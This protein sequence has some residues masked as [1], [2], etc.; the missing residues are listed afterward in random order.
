MASPRLLY[1]N[2]PFAANFVGPCLPGPAT[3]TE[4]FA[5]GAR[6]CCPQQDLSNSNATSPVDLEHDAGQERR[7]VAGEKEGGGPDVLRHRK[8][9]ERHGGAERGALSGVSSPRNIANSGVSPATGASAQTRILSGASS[10]A[11]DFVITCTAP[12]EAL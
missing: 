8:A 11:I 3:F 9:A 4:Y 7:L 5:A 1:K 2:W 10:T 12:F 6:E